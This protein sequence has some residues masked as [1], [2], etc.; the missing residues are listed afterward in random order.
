MWNVYRGDDHINPKKILERKYIYLTL[1]AIQFRNL[2]LLESNPDNAYVNTDAIYE[3]AIEE[4]EKK[5]LDRTT[6]VD[7]RLFLQ[8]LLQPQVKQIFEAF[9]RVD[10]RLADRKSVV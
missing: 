7:L 5:N 1:I 4:L 3:Q 6:N 2:R 8:Y 9:D 10:Q